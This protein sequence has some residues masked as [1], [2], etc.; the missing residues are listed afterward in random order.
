ML[1][2]LKILNTYS[3]IKWFIFI[4]K[5]GYVSKNLRYLK[6]NFSLEKLQLNKL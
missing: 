1:I 2:Y 6:Q 5:I 3:N 4:I